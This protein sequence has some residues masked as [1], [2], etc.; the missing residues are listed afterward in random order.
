MSSISNEVMS[1]IDELQLR[2]LDALDRKKMQVWADLFSKDVGSYICTTA[3][4]ESAGWKV[5]LIM[6]D[7]PGRI[8]DR[9]KFV[10]KVWNGTF[11]DYQT[12]HFV[13]R[14]ECEFLKDGLYKVLSSFNILYTRSDTGVTAS[15]ATGVYEDVIAIHGSEAHFCSKKVVTDAPMLPHYIV[16]PL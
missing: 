4:N 15:L 2:Y 9:V 14:M 13:Q 10:D 12:R 6:D 7:C 16:Y 1:V 5:A 3:E 8:Q 11:Q